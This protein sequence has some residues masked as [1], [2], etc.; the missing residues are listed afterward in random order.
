MISSTNPPPA[1]VHTTELHALPPDPTE[2]VG[3]RTMSSQPPMDDAV[4]TDA[5]GLIGLAGA[6]SVTGLDVFAFRGYA[7]QSV[8]VDGQAGSKVFKTK[9]ILSYISAVDSDIC[10]I[11]LFGH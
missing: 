7:E 1:T 6:A 5:V 11:E 8:V 2:R 4:D 10:T 3:S 9:E